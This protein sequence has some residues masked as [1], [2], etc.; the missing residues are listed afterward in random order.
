MLLT[1]TTSLAYQSVGVVHKK[2]NTTCHSQTGTLSSLL[3]LQTK[4]QTRTLKLSQ[5]PVSQPP[6]KK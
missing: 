6:R 2:I 3:A 5:Q 4:Q 1:S